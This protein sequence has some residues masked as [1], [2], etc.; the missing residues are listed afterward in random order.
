MRAMIIVQQSGS[1]LSALQQSEQYFLLQSFINSRSDVVTLQR[2]MR[3]ALPG[4]DSYARAAS[5][6]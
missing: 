1:E 4:S 3:D 2:S 6:M 5:S